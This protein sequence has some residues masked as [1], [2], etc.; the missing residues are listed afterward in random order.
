ME[1]KDGVEEGGGTGGDRFSFLASLTNLSVCM[2][3]D[4]RKNIHYQEKKNK[5]LQE[6]AESLLQQRTHT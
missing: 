6:P 2:L 5:C 3:Q 4:G 1:G